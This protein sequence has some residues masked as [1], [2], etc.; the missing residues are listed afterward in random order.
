MV[1]AIDPARTPGLIYLRKLSMQLASKMRFISAQ[2]LALF[3]DDLG[4]HAAGHANRM[5]A[6]LRTGL[7]ERIADGRI[8][9]LSFSQPTEANAVFAVLANEAADRI[10][11]RVRFYD[12]D[13][14]AGEV[15][16][17]TAWD[18]TEQDVDEF[19]AAVTE[20]LAR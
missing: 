10:R 7:E 11:K 12:W 4:L 13:R 2:L 14:A 20:E 5:A 15:R 1:V 6:R 18:T 19:I 17:M 9:G 3:T 8:S 16:W